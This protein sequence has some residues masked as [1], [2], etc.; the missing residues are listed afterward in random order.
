MLPRLHRAAKWGDGV[1]QGDPAPTGAKPPR[2]DDLIAHTAHELNNGLAVIRLT[3]DLLTQGAMAPER[4]GATILHEIDEAVRL[5]GRL[6]T[7]A[8]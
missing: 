4:A 6:R 8:P 5:I 2:T 7:P 1:V 3:A